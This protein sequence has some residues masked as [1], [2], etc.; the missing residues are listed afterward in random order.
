[1]FE[2]HAPTGQGEPANFGQLGNVFSQKVNHGYAY[3]SNRTHT[4]RQS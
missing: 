4:V 1:M 3:A 2:E